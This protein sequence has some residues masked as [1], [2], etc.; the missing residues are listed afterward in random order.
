MSDIEED[1]PT[2]EPL[3]GVNM[4]IHGP[5]DLP[6][7]SEPTQGEMD[8]VRVAQRE[9]AKKRAPQP[10]DDER[11]AMRQ[12]AVMEDFI[13]HPGWQIM[14]DLVNRRL[15]E[16]FAEILQPSGDPNNAMKLEYSKGRLEGFRLLARTPQGMIETGKAVRAKYSLAS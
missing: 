5:K 13:K 2:S 7:Q 11:D 4:Q 8:E 12:G 14:V 3:N 1:T 16:G 6:G 10:S 15:G 9:A